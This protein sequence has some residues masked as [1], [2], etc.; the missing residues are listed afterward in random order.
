M[1]TIESYDS[2]GTIPLV[3]SFAAVAVMLCGTAMAPGD[4]RA[5]AP[6]EAKQTEI[7][8]ITVG[9]ATRLTRM[10]FQNTSE[11]MVSRTGVVA[12][13]YPKPPREIK[14]Y[15]VSKDGGHTWGEEID[16]PANWSGAMSIGLSS[17]GVLKFHTN[18]SPIEG[19]PGWY[20]D[21]VDE[22]HDDFDPRSWKRWKTRVH[23]PDHAPGFDVLNP[24]MSK[25][26]AIELPG[27]DLL[28]PMYGQF[29]GDTYHR[30]YLARSTDQGRTW[31]FH[32]TM[33][34]VQQDPNP[35]MPGQYAGACEPS[36]ALL[37]NGQLLAVLRIQLA[38]FP[39]EYKPLYVC[40]SDDLGQTWTQPTP[41]T[42]HL[43]CIQPTV[44]ALD[45]GVVALEY[46]RPGCHVAFSLDNG[47]TWQDRVSFSKFATDPSL[48]QPTPA[49]P[50]TGSG[51]SVTGQ[52]DMTKVGPNGLV[53]IGNDEEG[54]KVWPITVQR[55]KVSPARV[56]L[57]GRILDQ[58]GNPVAGASVQRGP[59]RYALD[60]WLEDPAVM[61]HFARR[62]RLVGTPVLGYRP[63]NKAKL[64][65]TVKTDKEGRYRFESVKLGEYVLTVESDDYAPQYRHIKVE[66]QAD[67]EDFSMKA[68]LKVS[69]RVVD[70][71]GKPVAGACV[72]LNNWHSHTDPDGFFYWWVESPL[73]EEV[74]YR[75]DKRYSAEIPG[76]TA[77]K[78]KTLAGAV[79]LSTIARRPFVLHE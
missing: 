64:Y 52:F 15:R 47:H 55:V 36:V 34:S 76:S 50:G 48:L 21:T 58:N 77:M 32:A 67:A 5:E 75:V 39:G 62:P 11:V 57:E 20:E 31:R 73:P 12:A 17:G 28:M 70:S 1:A 68:G 30:S 61:D 33:A 13:L 79:P 35:E 78:Y 56:A 24:G 38:H 8:K 51:P 29:K 37:A 25:G 65:P 45:N 27:G 16:S 4:C 63:I 19:E 59:N 14:K 53:V 22:G 60:S 7:L 74:T 46:G 69:N 23:V 10:S 9:R 43:M 44:F 18:M 3:L 72:V 41:T 42:P 49:A 40:W 71:Q 66:P 6:A 2:R 26:P 54:T